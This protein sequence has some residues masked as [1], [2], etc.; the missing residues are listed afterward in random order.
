MQEI[1]EQ[2]LAM[3]GQNRLGVELDAFDGPFAVTYAHDLIVLRTRR[4]HE[5]GRKSRRIDGERMVTRRLERRGQA[6]KDAGAAVRDRRQLAV[7]HTLR[8][9]D[10]SAE[11][12]TYGLV[13]ETN[14]EDWNFAGEPLNQRN[15]YPRL[16][17][18]AR[19]RRNHDARRRK[20][21]DFV[22]RDRV[23]S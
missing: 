15:R 5:G 11:R 17:R 13:P 4:N 22:E 1:G 14:A 20:R 12:L 3:L 9:H 19:A 21:G 10:S 18:R 2:A 8:P 23:V 6:G 7:H 16:V